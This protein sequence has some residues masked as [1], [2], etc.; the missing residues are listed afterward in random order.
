MNL[1]FLLFKKCVLVNKNYSRCIFTKDE[2]TAL[3]FSL[4]H[5][6]VCSKK[7]YNKNYKFHCFFLRKIDL[8]IH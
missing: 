7:H 1:D 2:F 3:S 6:V 8:E 4:H 5:A